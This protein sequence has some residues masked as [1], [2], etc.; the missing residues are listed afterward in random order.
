MILFVLA[1]LF[2]V[3]SFLAGLHYSHIRMESNLEY[4]QYFKAIL[5]ARNLGVLFF[6]LGVIR[7]FFN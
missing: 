5:I 2:G 4:K 7:L 6:L 1:F 3:G